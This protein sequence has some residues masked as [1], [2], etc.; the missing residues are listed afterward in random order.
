MEIMNKLM[1]TTKTVIAK[2]DILELVLAVIFFPWSLLY[3]A[4]RVV[5]KWEI[6]NE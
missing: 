3:I 2:W 4:F 6:E 1:K 5:Q